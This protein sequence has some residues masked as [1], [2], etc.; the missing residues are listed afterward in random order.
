MHLKSTS[1]KHGLGDYLTSI[2]TILGFSIRSQESCHI[3]HSLLRMLKNR[4]PLK[5]PCSGGYLKSKLAYQVTLSDHLDYTH[6]LDPIP[7]TPGGLS[8]LPLESSYL[9]GSA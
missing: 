5:Q 6:T 7:D 3:L 8:S 1:Q 2:Q 4:V 9:K